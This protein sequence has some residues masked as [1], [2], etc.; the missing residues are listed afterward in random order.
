MPTEHCFRAADK[1]HYYAFAH[2][3]IAHMAQ[4][5]TYLPCDSRANN[6]NTIAIWTRPASDQPD[7]MPETPG[8][9]TMDGRHG[10]LDM[11]PHF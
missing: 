8:N 5:S 9:D 11:V 1:A 3:G 4:N 6:C 7:S 10:N 2:L